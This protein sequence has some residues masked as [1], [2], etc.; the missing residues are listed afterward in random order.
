[1]AVLFYIMLLLEARYNPFRCRLRCASAFQIMIKRKINTFSC[2]K[3]CKYKCE[4]IRTNNIHF[5]SIFALATWIATFVFCLWFPLILNILTILLYWWHFN[6][7]Y[8][9]STGNVIYEKRNKICNIINYIYF[10]KKVYAFLIY[11]FQDI[12]ILMSG[13]QTTS[14]V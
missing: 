8:F 5:F 12:R 4:K 6:A 7:F 1:M 14:P 9:I 11:I 13:F 10:N 2:K 3:T